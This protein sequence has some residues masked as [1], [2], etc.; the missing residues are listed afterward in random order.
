MQCEAQYYTYIYYDPSRNNEPFYIGKGKNERAW[1][2]LG[3][4]DRGKPHPLKH[5]LQFMKKN[6]IFPIIGIYSDLDEELAHLTEIE[7]ISKFGRKNLGKGTLLNLTD[8]GEGAS[9]CVRSAETRYK[10]GQANIGKNRSHSMISKLKISKSCK[11]R[12]DTNS[13]KK[14]K[15]IANTGIYNNNSKLTEQQVIDIFQSVESADTLS[16]RYSVSKVQIYSI[17]AKKYWKYITE[18]L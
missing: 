2:H 8:G 4:L 6:N 13:A 9:G 3:M 1:E 16:S 14:L 10:I 18:N 5:R 12:K 15:S 7:L 11:G 17:K